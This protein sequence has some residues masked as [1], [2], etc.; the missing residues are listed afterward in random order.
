M[1]KE[2]SKTVEWTSQKS[3]KVW[4]TTGFPSVQFLSVITMIIYLTLSKQLW[5]QIFVR[6]HYMP[7]KWWFFVNAAKNTGTL[8][9]LLV[10]KPSANGQFPQITRF[11]RKYVETVCR[12]KMSTSGNQKKFLHFTQGKLRLLLFTYVLYS[13]Q[14]EVF[15]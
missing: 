12:R 5:R 3:K 7:L 2:E 13:A 4:H 8:P 15:Q 11:T 9:N 10:R 1:Y 6:M 14:V